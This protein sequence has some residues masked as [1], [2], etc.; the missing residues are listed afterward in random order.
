MTNLENEVTKEAN[1]P[2]K[3]K[4]G[5]VLRADIYRPLGNGTWPVLLTR[6][7]YGKDNELY[8]FHDIPRAVRQGYVVIIQDT[9]GRALLQKGIGI[10]SLLQ[11]TKPLIA[12]KR[13]IGPQ[14]F[15]TAM[16]K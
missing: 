9:R 14:I 15:L 11:T 8:L 13:S 12:M 6:S 7:P 16:A 4:D 10:L 1:V 3:M 5:T 2:V